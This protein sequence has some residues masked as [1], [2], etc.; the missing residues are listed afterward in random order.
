MFGRVNRIGSSAVGQ[1]G[2][3]RSL[4]STKACEEPVAVQ[5]FILKRSGS[6]TVRGV[7][8]YNNTHD[9]VGIPDMRLELWLVWKLPHATMVGE[10]LRTH[11]NFREDHWS[12]KVQ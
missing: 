2:V 6:A 9:V 12:R 3:D 5:A 11:A 8:R 1:R 10:L 7:T 4:Q